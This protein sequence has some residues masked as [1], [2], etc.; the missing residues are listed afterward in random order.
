MGDR[1]IGL[2]EA[3]FGEMSRNVRR[4][5]RT[6][7]PLPKVTRRQFPTDFYEG[8]LSVALIATTNGKTGATKCKAKRWIPDPTSV[9]D[10]I[11]MVLDTVEYDLVNRSNKLPAAAIGTYCI[12]IRISSEWRIIW[13]DC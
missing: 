1:L 12:W 5:N 3:S 8:E 10:P 13:A 2:T 9:S 6:M 7:P 4:G 11:A